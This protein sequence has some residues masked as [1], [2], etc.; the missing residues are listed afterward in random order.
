MSKTSTLA[1]TPRVDRI[2]ARDDSTVVFALSYP[3]ST[4]ILTLANP[5]NFTVHVAE[6]RR[7]MQQF[8]TRV[9]D[10]QAHML[11]TLWWSRI[12]PHRTV[13]QGW[14]ISPRHYQNQDLT[15]V[16]LAP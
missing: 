16:W 4:F 10:E 1:A 5:F 9:L 2:Y 13:V 14:K 11:I 7:F 6:Q 15:T 3:S 12:I 8:E